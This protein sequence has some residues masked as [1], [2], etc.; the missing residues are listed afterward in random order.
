MNVSRIRHALV[1]A[2]LFAAVASPGHAK[3]GI[4]PGPIVMSDEEKLLEADPAQGIEHAV[5]LV[6][7]TTRI[8]NAGPVMRI[9]F[10]LRAKILSNEGRALADIEIPFPRKGAKLREFWGRTI[11][12]DGTVHELKKT[13]LDRQ[14]LVKAGRSGIEIAKAALPGVVPGC[15]IDFGYVLTMNGYYPYDR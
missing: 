1:P 13:D 9:V 8:E 15:V 12:P 4:G 6:E 11:L 14:V 3:K 10:H 2:I 7:E 5:I